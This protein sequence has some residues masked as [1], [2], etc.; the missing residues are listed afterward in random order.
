[1]RLLLVR[2]G[3]IPSNVRGVLDTAVPGPA[4][5]ALGEEQARALPDALGGHPI[6][7]LW[8]SSALRA[9]QTAAPLARHLGI[10]PVQRDGIR[11]I[12]AGNLE[13]SGRR[14]DID[15][16]VETVVAWAGGDLE[17]RMPG[18]ETGHEFF[19]RYDSVVAEAVSLSDDEGSEAVVLVSHGAAIRCWAGSRAD[20]LNLENTAHLWLDNTGVVVLEQ[21]G[22]GWT[23]LTWA[24]D[25]ITGI[26][27]AAPAGPTGEPQ[28]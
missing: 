17:R 5:T 13:M 9:Q 14:P 15:V 24:G 26:G 3:Q 18:G 23:C 27:A 12:S 19:H 7:G 25:P 8:V 4:L 11:E 20:N 21:T 2:H 10:E 28:R 6:G 16:Y 1:V 22:R